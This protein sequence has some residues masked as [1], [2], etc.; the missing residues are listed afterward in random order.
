[1][2]PKKRTSMYTDGHSYS[3]FDPEEIHRDLRL[4]PVRARTVMARSKQ[5]QAAHEFCQEC[6]DID[7]ELSST[8][9]PGEHGS[10]ESLDAAIIAHA[11]NRTRFVISRANLARMLQLGPSEQVARLYVTEDPQ[12]L[13][14]I[15]TGEHFPPVPDGQETPISK[16]SRVQATPR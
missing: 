10:Y 12:L 11:E 14:V 5:I 15:V 3:L 9:T 16:M 1:M 2:A 8:A 4:D 7:R 6:R 13:H